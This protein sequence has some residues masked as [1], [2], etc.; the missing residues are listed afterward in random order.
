MLNCGNVAERRNEDTGTDRVWVTCWI[1][2]YHHC[3]N[4][5]DGLIKETVAI[6]VPMLITSEFVQL[7]STY[8]ENMQG[9]TLYP[10]EFIEI[11]MK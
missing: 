7:Q 11:L 10:L 4:C 9:E 5:A 2:A 6:S 1:K 3:I 8:Y